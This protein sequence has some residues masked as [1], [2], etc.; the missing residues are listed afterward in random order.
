M[1]VGMA[2]VATE[3]VRE[4]ATEAVV[5][6]AAKAE[7]ERAVETEEEATATHCCWSVQIQSLKSQSTVAEAKA[8]VAEAMVEVGVEGRAEPVV[9]A[10]EAKEG[11]ETGCRSTARSMCDGYQ[12][13]Y[14]SILWSKARMPTRRR[15]ENFV[16]SCSRRSAWR[17]PQNLA[18][19]P[20]RCLSPASH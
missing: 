17:C 10:V 2:A 13:E 5:T 6:E 7:V 3:E 9:R 19:R 1:E 4:V 12:L 8:K 16:G 14:V 20:G 11:A 18:T 15:F